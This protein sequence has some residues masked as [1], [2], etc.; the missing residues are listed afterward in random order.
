[1]PTTIVEDTVIRTIVEDGSD[2][3]IIEDLVTSTT[4]VQEPDSDILVEEKPTIIVV[5]T[6]EKEIISE[7]VQGPPGIDATG[8]LQIN[9]G[10][11]TAGDTVLVDQ[12][13]IMLFRSVKWLV[14][15]REIIGPLYNYSEIAAIHN[16]TVAAHWRAGIL[17]DMI[18]NEELVDLSGGFLRLRITN[19]HTEDLNVSVLR[20]GTLN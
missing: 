3:E 2:I 19:N 6:I 12:I 4:I 13:S 14:T 10:P 9:V 7:G 15:L 8:V 16:D 5:E 1:M 20:L 11:I 17:F 18:N